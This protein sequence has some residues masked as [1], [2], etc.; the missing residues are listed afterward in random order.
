MR[1]LHNY[2]LFFVFVRKTFV[3]MTFYRK[4]FAYNKL[5]LYICIKQKI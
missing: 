5:L 1:T 4:K 2:P 3:I